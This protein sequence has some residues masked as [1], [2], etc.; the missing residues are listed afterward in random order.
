MI[1]SEDIFDHLAHYGV[2]GMKW[3]VRKDRRTGIPRGTPRAKGGKT[4]KELREIERRKKAA[5]NRRTLSD[6]EIESR[7]K[8]LKMEK[9]LKQLTDNDVSPGKVLV[10]RLMGDTGNQAWRMV[11]AA[12]A[13]GIAL[14]VKTQF[15]K[16]A[17]GPDFKFDYKDIPRY[18]APNPNR[19][20]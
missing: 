10:R 14:A 5:K 7:I 3:G 17:D 9:E 2:L 6:S 13:G 15:D 19:K 16:K 1:D 8:R 4:Q 18:V 20:K 11:L 12:M